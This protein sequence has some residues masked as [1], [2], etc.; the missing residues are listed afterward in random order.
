MDSYGNR[1]EVRSIFMQEPGMASPSKPRA[2]DHL[3]LPVTEIGDARERYEALGFTVAPAAQHPFGTENC[4]IFLADGTFLEP[5]GIAQRET[6]EAAAI[7]G[8]TFIRNDQTYRFRCGEE[9]FSHLV[10]KTEDAKADHALYKRSGI[11]GGRKVRF[12]RVFQTPDGESGKVSF[13]LAFAADQRSPDTGFFACEVVTSTKADRSALQE[14]ENGAVRLKEVIATEINPTDFQYF[15]QVFL[16]QRHM[17]ADSFRM[18]FETSNTKV[19]VLTP[20]GARAFYGIEAG[21]SERGMRFQ[22]FV[23]AVSDLPALKHR[24][25]SADI[26]FHMRGGSLVVPSASGQGATIIFEADT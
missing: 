24:L 22:A 10:L 23:L 7:N 20:E 11:S 19:S 18:S 2:I 16:N 4:C 14:H 26:A 5:L 1:L 8:N 9:G 17:D 25:E 21:Q 13:K 12:S 3:V 15:W 6:C